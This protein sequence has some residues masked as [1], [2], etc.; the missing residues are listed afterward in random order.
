MGEVEESETTF[1]SPSNFSTFMIRLSV[2]GVPI[3]MNARESNSLWKL[4][5]IPSQ[6]N[7]AFWKVGCILSAIKFFGAQ[8][9]N[10]ST[11]DMRKSTLAKGEREREAQALPSDMYVRTP[12]PDA[13]VSG[14]PSCS[15]RRRARAFREHLLTGK[16]EE[17]SVLSRSEVKEGKGRRQTAKEEKRKCVAPAPLTKQAEKMQKKREA[18][19]PPPP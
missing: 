4:K 15:R 9:L 8:I 12:I 11:S 2:I 7:I 6:V 18:V 14:G 17:R 10:S 13:C 5:C 1:L 3:S 19:P 16:R